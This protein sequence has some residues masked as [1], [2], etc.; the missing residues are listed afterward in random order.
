MTLAQGPPAPGGAP[1][2]PRGSATVTPASKAGPGIRRGNATIT[3][4]S[5]AGSTIPVA[6]PP[7]PGASNVAAPPTPG[8]GHADDVSDEKYPLKFQDMPLDL[9]LQDYAKM[10]GLTLLMAPGLPKATITLRSQDA[11]AL[12]DYLMAIETVLNMNGVGLVPKGEKFVKVVANKTIVQEG[13]TI[14]QQRIETVTGPTGDVHQV[15]VPIPEMGQ[16]VSQLIGLKHI[17]VTEVSKAI[18]PLKHPYASVTLYERINSVLLTDTA[19]NVNRIARV[20]GFIDQP[21]IVREEPHLR[22]IKHAK[23]SEIKQKIDEIVTESQKDETGKPKSV[24]ATKSSG[25]PGVVKRTLPGVIRAKPAKPA[26]PTPV[27]SKL[28]EQEAERGIIHG[29]VLTIADD[30]TNILIIM[31]RPENMRFFDSVID[32]LDVATDPDVIVKV[33]RLEYAESE[34]IAEMLNEL[35]GASSSKDEGKPAAG[36]A[37]TGEG[38]DA[39]SATLKE[40]VARQT[41]KSSKKE[42]GQSKVGEL[43]SDNIKILSDER[44]NSLIIMASKGDIATLDQIIKDMD[45]MLLQVGIEAV[46]LEI[47]LGDS[48]QSGIDWV[49]RSMIAYNQRGDGSGNPLFAFAGGGGGGDSTPLDAAAV[50]A[51]ALSGGLTYY[52]SHF[53]WNLDA[54]IAMTA[55]D[56]R[57]KILS[58]PIIVTHDNTEATIDASQ[59]RYFYKGQRYVGGSYNSAGGRYEPDVE[60]RKVGIKLKVTPHV[61][62]KRFVVMEIE[63]S[64]EQLAEGQTIGD[65]TWPTVLSREFTAEIAVG[66]RE[67]VVLG[68]LV[69]DQENDSQT[70]IPL[71][72]D[73]P[74]FGKLF[75]FTKKETSRSEVV[76]F[77]TPYVLDTPDAI[78]SESRRR[79]DALEAGDIWKRGWSDS[80][81]A[82]AEA[83]VDREESAVFYEV[84]DETPTMLPLGQIEVVPPLDEAPASR[85]P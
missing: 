81:L 11:L 24:V 13:L 75:S 35:I 73:I 19:D 57:T 32:V 79:K 43:S 60:R 84:E 12:E 28:I 1:P 29:K 76:V 34:T 83:H 63:Q 50:G 9:I 54:V 56:S 17:D 45:M 18:E 55:G 47:E 16:M 37:K 3:P 53:D 74:L 22:S 67:T 39:K 6:T 27:A 62:E 85:A 82:G 14:Q 40:Y 72:K 59:E 64:V 5:R 41:G 52:F 68:G 66:D 31:T 49:Q 61:N 46:I 42:P 71:L 21:S 69:K 2:A 23:A 65:T 25:S 77:I 20:I 10:T 4:T 51:P 48:I 36:A 7:V 33:F 30:R 38:A 8:G 78:Q 58:S 44:T 15:V 70:G 26:T 80:K